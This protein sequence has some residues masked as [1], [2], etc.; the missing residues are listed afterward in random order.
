M[1]RIGRLVIIGLMATITGVGRVVVFALVTGEAI[2]GYGCMRPCQHI[3]IIMIWEQRRLPV[4]IGSVAG[5]AIRR[6]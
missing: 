4:R 1:R 3:I 5:L 6:D 2:G